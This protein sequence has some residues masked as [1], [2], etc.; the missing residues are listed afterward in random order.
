MSTKMIARLAVTGAVAVGAALSGVAV[1]AAPAAAAPPPRCT[2][3]NL[4]ARFVGPHEGAAGTEFTDVRITNNG[5]KDCTLQGIPSGRFLRLGTVV[6]A[7]SRYVGWED[8]SGQVRLRTVVLDSDGSRAYVR[9]GI[10][11]AGDFGKGCR[12]VTPTALR[13]TLPRSSETVRVPFGSYDVQACTNK[14]DTQLTVS[15]FLSHRTTTS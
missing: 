8:S 11:D 2:G 9:V 1:A 5:T 14:K 3:E 4:S 15:Q 10:E 13:I 12:P 6:G 7:Q